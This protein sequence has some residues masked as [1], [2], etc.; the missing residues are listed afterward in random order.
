ML[1]EA[2]EIEWNV[3]FWWEAAIYYKWW[4]FPHLVI[5]EAEISNLVSI[6]NS[7]MEH[8]QASL[9]K[10]KNITILI[11]LLVLDDDLKMP[12]NRKFSILKSR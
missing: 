3:I 6:T 1:V 4:F 8:V 2:N 10:D 11:A 9:L 5:W 12:I 7:H